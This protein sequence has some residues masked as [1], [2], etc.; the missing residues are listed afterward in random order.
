MAERLNRWR[1]LC[2]RANSRACPPAGSGIVRG[3]VSRSRQL[4]QKSPVSPWTQPLWLLPAGFDRPVGCCPALEPAML[5]WL[6][7]IAVTPGSVSQPAAD[8][9]QDENFA[10][11]P[12]LDLLSAHRSEQH[13]GCSKASSRVAIPW[14]S[15]RITGHSTASG[16]RRCGSRHYIFFPG[17]HPGCTAHSS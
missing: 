3:L 6:P 16:E 15:T 13:G 14:R 17:H 9:C 7:L 11:P 5:R 4:S 2:R 10:P 8:S 1:R 12:L